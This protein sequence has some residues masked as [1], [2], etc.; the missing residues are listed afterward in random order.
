MSFESLEIIKPI[1][2]ALESEGYASPTAI[3]K[4]VIPVIFEG[5]DIL[6]CAR[7][8]T[9]K[10]AAFAV[11][12]IQ[13][14]SSSFTETPRKI[15]TLILS[16]AKEFAVRVGES[17]SVYEKNT[18]LKNAVVYE[19]ASQVRQTNKL[20][21]GVDILVATPG[22]LLDLVGKGFVD[23]T[24]IEIF[25]LDEA[26]RMLDM[27]LID[28]I[29]KIISELPEKRQSLF[30]SETMSPEIIKLS[31]TIL[32][33]PV[34]IETESK[35]K[36]ITKLTKM[37][38]PVIRDHPY[39]SEP[40]VEEKPVIKE[41]RRG[42]K[43]AS[44]GNKTKPALV[45]KESNPRKKRSENKKA[46]S[47]Q[48]DIKF[49]DT[50]TDIALPEPVIPTPETEK[51]TAGEQN[52]TAEVQ[53]SSPKMQQPGYENKNQF[54]NH[55]KLFHKKKKH[56]RENRQNQGKKYQQQ[57][58]KK[59]PEKIKPVLDNRSTS[60]LQSAEN[61]NRLASRNQAK[62]QK[63]NNAG[64]RKFSKVW[65]NH[66]EFITIGYKKEKKYSNNGTNNSNNGFS[67]QGN[68]NKSR[69]NSGYSSKAWSNYGRPGNQK[70]N[71]GRKKDS[72]YYGNSEG[73]DNINNE[74]ILNN[75]SRNGNNQYKKK[76]T[77]SNKNNWKK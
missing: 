17:F 10:T 6:V 24:S 67:K 20:K 70:F 23:L 12:I 52:I 3:Q 38:I 9:G 40:D 45:K 11:P 62:L 1:I 57:D 66:E 53:Q 29:K 4:Q 65:T 22:R 34:L 15:R 75:D 72:G 7:P 51:E 16:P 31:E 8:G 2:S 74:N 76:F 60:E 47:S 25:V 14:L 41:K 54:H 37:P 28:D 42:S 49:T 44:S 33:E 77:G 27:D 50:E 13:K 48:A 19:S 58:Q 59:Q 5:K 32:N 69:Q 56:V 18:K 64:E 26:A 55:K 35:T 43:Q 63:I 30:F 39:N 61:L 46:V 73:S 71:H 21:K 68:K 36:E